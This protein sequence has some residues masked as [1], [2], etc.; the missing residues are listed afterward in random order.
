MKKVRT[1]AALGLFD[2]V[3]LGHRAV[4]KEALAQKQNGLMPCAFT[5]SPV[6]SAEKGAKFI[7]SMA[8]KE[9]IIK[10]I[11]FIDRIFSH[12]FDDICNM[13]GEAFVKD[14]ICGEMKAAHVVCGSDFRFGK[15]AAWGTYDLEKF[16]KKY[17]FTV[18]TIEDVCLGGERVSST[19]IRRLLA[20]GELR[21]ANLLL[22]KPYMIMR[23]VR[24][25]VQL[26]RTLGFPTAN[27]VFGL[28]QLV[29]K[30]GVYSSRT[31]A[32][33]KWYPSMT[34]IGVKPTVEYGGAPLAET[35]IHGFSGDL[36]GSTLQVVLLDFIRP[37]KRFDS[38]DELKEQISR[39][40]DRAVNPLF[41]L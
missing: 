5:F 41:S 20:A 31:L 35:Y 3:H 18:Q 4:L 25:G 29:P 28:G 22:G 23:E 36:Y 21:K 34:N 32:D 39:D 30:F 9:Y 37:E 13:N 16:G 2:G 15:G 8:E 6:S 19:E 24:H 40:V 11:C 38:T 7:Y 14:I 12:D 1:S 33:G 17:G 10:E 26:G 27:Q